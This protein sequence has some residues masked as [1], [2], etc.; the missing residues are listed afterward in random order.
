MHLQM[1][2]NRKQGSVL[3]LTLFLVTLAA[4]ALTVFIEKA[5]SEIMGEAVYLKR[6]ELRMEA[7]SALETAAAIMFN[8]ERLDRELYAPEQGWGDP[9]A[10]AGVEFPDRITVDIEFVDEMGKIPLAVANEEQMLRLFE[11]LGF[12]DIAS[13]ELTSALRSWVNFGEAQNSFDA[14]DRDYERATIPYRPPYRP[15]NSYYELSAIAGF[16][17]TFFNENGDPNALFYRFT[18]LVS[19]YNFNTININTADPAVLRI[20]SGLGESE[21]AALDRQ[22]GLQLSEKPYFE[23]LQ[24]ASTQLGIPLGAGFGV[25]TQC[26]Q[27][28][29]RVSDG[30]ADFLLSATLAPASQAD[31]P[32]P[33]SQIN[34][35]PGEHLG[36]NQPPPQQRRGGARRQP[37]QPQIGQEMVPYPYRFLEI[38]ENENIL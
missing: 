33:P 17:E 15:L 23:N 35:P 24:E 34:I 20:W 26:V 8:V 19:L 32:R 14:H 25:S 18:S 28:N 7:Y 4:F 38:R 27:V 13:Q 30:T 12:D 10:L 29:I 16:R 6:D 36:Q 31:S 37:N 11:V 5:F 1:I 22:G 2:H 3:L 9:F 21:M